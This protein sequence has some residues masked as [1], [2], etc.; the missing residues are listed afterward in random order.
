MTTHTTLDD[1]GCGEGLAPATPVRIENRP[2]LSAINYRTGTHARFKRSMLARLTQFGLSSFPALSHLTTREDDDFT[3]ALLDSWATVAHVLTF[4]QERI[5]N[6]AFIRTAQERFSLAHLARLIGYVPRPGVAANTF[7]A[8][9]LDDTPGAPQEVV[10]D[11][12]LKVQSIPGPGELPQTYETVETITAYPI[13]NAIQPRTTQPQALTTAATRITINGLDSGLRKG[14]YVLIVA[15]Q[16]DKVVKRVSRVQPNP[17]KNTTT[18]DLAEL[19]APEYFISPIIYTTG[20]YQ[21]GVG[22]S[23]N[24]V[25]NYVLGQSLPMS[26]LLATA[27]VNSWQVQDLIYSVNFTLQQPFVPSDPGL[28]VFAMRQ[29][30]GVFGHNAPNWNTL[31]SDQR[32]ATSWEGRSLADDSDNQGHIYLDNVY[33]GIVDESWIAL[34]RPNADP[35]ILRVQKAEEKSRADYLLSNKVTLLTVD[36]QNNSTNGFNSFTLRETTVLAQSEPLTLS[37][38]PITGPLSGGEILLNGLYPYL[39]PGQVAILT[40]QRSDLVGVTASEV[41]TIEDVTVVGGYTRI[42]L[43]NSL[44]NSYLLDTVTINANVA[45]A[46]H[47]ETVSEVL[48]SGDPAQTFQRFKLRRPPLTYLSAETSGG[49]ASTLEVRVN[50]VRW[51]EVPNFYQRGPDERIYIVTIEDDGT[52]TVQFGDGQAGARPPTGAENI[53]ATYR[54]GIG[55]A[56]L[57]KADQL[58]IML[59]KPL[60][61]RSVTNP[62][63]SSG[64]QDRDAPEEIRRNASLPI[65][66]LERLVSLRDYEDFARAFAGVAKALATWTWDGSQRGVFLTVAGADGADILPGSTEYENL[67]DAL[68]TSGDPYVTVTVKTYRRG[69]FQVEGRVQVHEDYIPDDVITAVHEALRAAYAFDMREFGQPV[70][71]SEVIAT[72]QAV[73][74]VVAVDIDRLFRTGS[75]ATLN[76]RLPAA[77]PQAG[78]SAAAIDAAELL[79]LDARPIEIGVMS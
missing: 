9:T 78:A 69:L 3:I 26:D 64:A 51:G 37:E 56:G 5:A 36:D 54:K 35:K 17:P 76:T 58:K 49:V 71:L 75:A 70:A 61:V 40:G 67:L 46:T 18:L 33:S 21:Y 30:T 55:V 68:H 45:P 34:L 74:G 27:F 12:G 2:G 4:Y 11:P 14:D 22:L 50:G 19:P 31:P 7:L 63:A 79:T 16:T 25:Q 1:C 62:L 13:H 6:E 73:P 29:R 38:I 28:G 8:F 42:T 60:G 10:I 32:P 15:S 24:T 72:I 20:T 59:T 48:G 44:V 23:N 77:L 57:V 52:T 41:I 53:T 65:I 43:A 66:A 39:Q 47:G